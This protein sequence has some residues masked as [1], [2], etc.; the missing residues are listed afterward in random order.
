MPNLMLTLQPWWTV[1][2]LLI[3][4]DLFI[5]F[6]ITQGIISLSF[7][8]T[9]LPRITGSFL[10]LG[11]AFVLLLHSFYCHF[12]ISW[13]LVLTHSF[14]S[15]WTKSPQKENYILMHSGIGTLSF[16]KNVTNADSP[17]K[18]ACFSI[19]LNYIFMLIEESDM[20]Q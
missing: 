17:T 6:Y 3:S 15:S 12:F 4:K 20:L 16:Y 14:L 1:C 18:Y 11:Y 13:T 10:F 19:G 2:E 5:F 7:L 9:L 8:N